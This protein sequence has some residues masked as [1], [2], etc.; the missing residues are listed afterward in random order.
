[1]MWSEEDRR[2]LVF[3]LN[4]AISQ[5]SY[6]HCLNHTFR[7]RSDEYFY[8]TITS[9]HVRLWKYLNFRPTLDRWRTRVT[10][11]TSG[12]HISTCHERLCVICFVVWPTRF[13]YEMA[14]MPRCWEFYPQDGGDEQNVNKN[15]VEYIGKTPTPPSCGY[16]SQKR[17]IPDRVEV[18]TTVYLKAKV[19]AGW[20]LVSRAWADR[21]SPLRGEQVPNLVGRWSNPKTLWC[22]AKVFLY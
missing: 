1:M 11:S 6:S 8:G 7:W 20:S 10:C 9:S 2:R 21:P 17:G 15:N 18:W 4:F 3:I 5:S 12:R 13:A 14:G 19:T 16:N 22:R